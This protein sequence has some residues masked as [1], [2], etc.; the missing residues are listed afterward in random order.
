MTQNPYK[1]LDAFNKEDKDVFFG[2]EREVEE[3][4]SRLFQGNLL[5]I[6]GPSGTGK[7][8]LIQCGIAN[9]IPDSDWKPLFIR[10]NE[11]IILALNNALEKEAKTVFNST[12][13]S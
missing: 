11:D 4:Y 7:T 13:R 3:I 1:F 10:R 2:R 6:Y 8:S 5:V 12:L 9:K